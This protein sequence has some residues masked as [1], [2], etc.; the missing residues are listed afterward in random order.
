MKKAVELMDWIVNEKSVRGSRPN[1][2]GLWISHSPKPL[3]FCPQTR[4]ITVE[5]GDS[6][7]L[8]KNTVCKAIG[9]DKKSDSILAKLPS[10]KL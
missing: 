6:F 5:N 7:L 4:I 1:D 2:N 8:N 10:S 9:L 3:S